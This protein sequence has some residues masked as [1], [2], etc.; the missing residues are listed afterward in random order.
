MIS[1]ILPEYKYLNIWYHEYFLNKNIP[2]YYWLKTE[3]ILGEIW[4]P[5]LP[6]QSFHRC[7]AIITLFVLGGR[8]ALYCDHRIFT[9][10]HRGADFTLIHRGADKRQFHTTRVFCFLNIERSSVFFCV[11]RY[12]HEIYWHLIQYSY[13]IQYAAMAIQLMQLTKNSCFVSSARKLV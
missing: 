5:P 2:T 13:N 6:N 11:L 4:F 3:W 8:E 9:A 10:I 7:K 1:R 12:V